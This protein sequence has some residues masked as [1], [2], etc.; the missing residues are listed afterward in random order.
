MITI[1]Q[2]KVAKTLYEETKPIRGTDIRPLN[3]RR[4]KHHAVE[5]FDAD[6]QI[7]SYKLYDTHVLKFYPDGKVG[8][9]I[10][11]KDHH[12][13]TTAEFISDYARYICAVRHNNRLWII[14]GD[15]NWPMPDNGELLF[16]PHKDTTRDAMQVAHK[17][18]AKK[19]VVNRQRAKE[20][21]E[22]YRKFIAF[23]KS[24]LT[25]SDGW[26]M[27]ETV[28]QFCNYEMW[29]KTFA[30][31]GPTHARFDVPRGRYNI[32]RIL[33]IIN[34]GEDSWLK[35]FVYVTMAMAVKESEIVPFDTGLACKCKYGVKQFSD[36]MLNRIEEANDVHDIIEVEAN[37]T[38]VRAYI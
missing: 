4:K 17:V 5:L 31:T 34:E 13:R 23:G 7:Y 33:D 14:C 12:T 15:S 10:D 20:A 11:S 38:F 3:N 35:A 19:K 27:P 36:Y 8:V 30:G 18:Y 6:K 29:D 2:W 28:A 24:L 26:V 1:N 32:S 22:P 9:N 25:I 16:E 37:G 21:R